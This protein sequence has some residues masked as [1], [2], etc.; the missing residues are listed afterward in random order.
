M[1]LSSIIKEQLITKRMNS[2]LGCIL[3]SAV[4]ILMAWMIA[5]FNLPGAIILPA[6]LLGLFLLFFVILEPEFGF[7]FAI[8]FAFFHSFLLFILLRAYTVKPGLLIDSSVWITAI[9]LLIFKSR[10]KSTGWALY[11]SAT[12]LVY[13]AYFLFFILEIVNPDH[14]SLLGWVMEFRREL[15]IFL[16]FYIS[17]EVFRDLTVFRRFIS[18]WLTLATICALYGCAQQIFGFIPGEKAFIFLSQDVLLRIYVD[19]HFRRFSIFPD[20]TSFGIFMGFSAIFFLSQLSGP[21]S[22]G[23]KITYFCCSLVMIAGML[24]S[25]TRTA[26][27]MIP[28]GFFIFCIMTLNRKESIYVIAIGALTLLFILFAP[29]H[30]PTLERLRTLFLGSSDPSMNIRNVHRKQIQPF[31]QAHP[32]G[33]GIATAGVKGKQFNPGGPLAGFPP[34]SELLGRGLELGYLGLIIYMLKL[35]IPMLTGLNGYFAAKD[36]EIKSYLIS[37]VAVFFS[38]VMSLYSQEISLYTSVFLSILSAFI[39][40]LIRFDTA[41]PVTDRLVKLK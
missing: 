33:A 5:Y 28:V 19:G 34:D 38:I 31:I 16:L 20:P 41:T 15:S 26:Y 9:S 1:N 32:I 14:P 6:M 11:G 13:I 18:F 17:L 21:V 4:S 35:F 22:P 23:K 29:V 36:A 10:N 12:S 24:F 30:N 8:L 27:A 40:K 2:A 25:G 37:L 39:I 7:Y 3:L